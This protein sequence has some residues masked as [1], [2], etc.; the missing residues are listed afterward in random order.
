MM[1]WAYID[2]EIVLFDCQRINII[3]LISIGENVLE[4]VLY[5]SHLFVLRLD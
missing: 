2:L 5:V 4:S 1:E 3:I